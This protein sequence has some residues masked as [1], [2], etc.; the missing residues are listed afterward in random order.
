MGFW[1]AA[2]ER[3]AISQGSA[4]KCTLS[5]RSGH[6]VHVSDEWEAASKEDHQES[7]H[8]LPYEPRGSR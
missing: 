4:G 6:R 1:L 7:A 5:V 8:I 2:G 3:K